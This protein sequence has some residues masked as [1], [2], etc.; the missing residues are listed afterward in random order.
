MLD[1]TYENTVLLTE[2]NILKRE[3]LSYFGNGNE[4]H[5]IYN[6]SLPLLLHTMIN[7][8]CT[9]LR[10]WA[11]TMPPTQMGNSY[12]NFISSHD[13]IGLR[14]A[15]GLLNNKELHILAETM[16]KFGGKISSEKITVEI[17]HLMK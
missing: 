4:A 17:F 2:T 15:E 14:P 7:S 1:Y 9:R 13:G 12:L 16:V 8:D 5:W 6:F 3:N 11:M 10:Q